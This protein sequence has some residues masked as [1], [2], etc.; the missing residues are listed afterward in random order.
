MSNLKLDVK[1]C[2]RILETKMTR[3]KVPF[4]LSIIAV[5]VGLAAIS[6]LLAGAA[7]PVLGILDCAGVI[8]T[9]FGIIGLLIGSLVLG[10]I[11]FLLGVYLWRLANRI[12]DEVSRIEEEANRIQDDVN[13]CL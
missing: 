9:G 2:R 3:E 7:L 11:L 8:S 1:T 4:A 6:S 12:E 5:M 13:Q 10:P